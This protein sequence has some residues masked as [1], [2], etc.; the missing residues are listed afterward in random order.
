MTGRGDRID[1]AWASRAGDREVGSWSSQT[2]DLNIDTRRFLARQL[3]LLGIA[4]TD[5][6][7]VRIMSLGGISGHGAGSLVFQWGSTIKSP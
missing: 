3:A 5:W 1:R 2:S 7:S 4:R 6:L